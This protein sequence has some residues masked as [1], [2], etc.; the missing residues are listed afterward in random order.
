M[1]L[2][3]SACVAAW[4]ICC[5]ALAGRLGAR[6][7]VIDRPDGS[8]KMHAAPMPLIGGLALMPPVA[9]YALLQTSLA[10]DPAPVLLALAVAGLGAMVMGFLDDRR[11]LGVSDRLLISCGLCIVAIAIESKMLLTTLELGPRHVL[12]LGPAAW[13]MTILCLV[14]LQSAINMADGQDGLVS[15]LSIVLVLCMFFYAPSVLR[16]YLLMLL[17]GLIIILYYNCRGKLFLGDAGSLSLGLVLG[18][19]AIYLYRHESSQLPLLTVLLLFFIPVVD[20]LRLMVERIRARRTPWSA[21]CDHLH[22]R[23]A[24]AWPWPKCVFIYLGI[25]A[26]PPLLASIWPVAALPLVA[27]TLLLYV[28]G[29][30][31]A[32]R[33]PAEAL[34]AARHE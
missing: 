1:L 27:I 15:S 17:L 26:V 12:L 21:D 32:S 28:Q 6:L 23:L 4:V 34:G 11:G 3:A 29:L 24:R 13:P 18:L 5:C 2:F 19:L 30:R 25:A 10:D 8:R 20:C 22:H 14:G 33:P 7:G 31:A 9:A 16:G